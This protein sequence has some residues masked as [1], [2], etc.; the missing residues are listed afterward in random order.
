MGVKLANCLTLMC[1]VADC[2]IKVTVG[3]RCVEGDERSPP[4]PCTLTEYLLGLTVSHDE[5]D[6]VSDSVVSL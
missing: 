3:S 4:G 6:C 2:M 1:I 5:A